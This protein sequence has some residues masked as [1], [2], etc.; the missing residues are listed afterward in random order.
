M[1]RVCW[2][3]N[4]FGRE[5]VSARKLAIAGSFVLEAGNFC[6]LLTLAAIWRTLCRIDFTVGKLSSD[7]LSVNKQAIHFQSV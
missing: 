4:T 5:Y 1:T 3:E 7:L 2:E 6:N